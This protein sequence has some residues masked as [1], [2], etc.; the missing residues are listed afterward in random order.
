MARNYAVADSVILAAATN[1][2]V[3]SVTYVGFWNS[4]PIQDNLPINLLEMMI[5]FLPRPYSKYNYRNVP[6]ALQYQLAHYKE[7]IIK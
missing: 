4:L 1:D 5:C 3:S 7:S 2:Y 6:I